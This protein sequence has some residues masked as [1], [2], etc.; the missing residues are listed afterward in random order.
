MINNF[1]KNA[2]ENTCKDFDLLDKKSFSHQWGNSDWI[3]RKLNNKKQKGVLLGDGVG[4]GKTY[5]ALFGALLYYVQHVMYKQYKDTSIL[6]VCPNQAVISKWRRD[7]FYIDPNKPN[8]TDYVKNIKETKK[9]IKSKNKLNQLLDEGNIVYLSEIQR[10]GKKE[11]LIKGAKHRIIFAT[12]HDIHKYFRGRSN[13][14]KNKLEE[15]IQI[16]II[17]EAHKLKQPK[18]DEITN[19]K[20]FLP[21]SKKI[22]LTATPF[23]K[24]AGELRKLLR[25][26]DKEKDAE[27]FKKYRDKFD[28]SELD[29][30]KQ[31]KIEL[32][33]RFRQYIAVRNKPFYN[34]KVFVNNKEV[35]QNIDKP[36][37][38]A[39]FG[40]LRKTS[41]KNGQQAINSSFYLYYLKERAA[42]CNVDEML[43]YQKLSL[44]LSM[45][46]SIAN[47]LAKHPKVELLLEILNNRFLVDPNNF[48]CKPVVFAGMN[49][50]TKK[51]KGL[52]KYLKEIIIDHYESQL[53][54]H[55]HEL[56]NSELPN[57]HPMLKRIF[58]DYPVNKKAKID[59]H[60]FAKEL[61]EKLKAS[62]LYQF[63]IKNG[64]KIK[65]YYEAEFKNIAEQYCDCC[66]TIS[67][68]NWSSKVKIEDFESHD[69]F[70]GFMKR[71]KKHLQVTLESMSPGE[72]LV[73]TYSSNESASQQKK[74]LAAFQSPLEPFVLIVSNA[75]SEGLDMQNYSRG[76]IH[77][78]MTWSPGLM[79]QRNGRINRIGKK[80]PKNQA[81]ENHYLIIPNTYDERIF[82]ALHKRMKALN[83]LIPVDV[84]SEKLFIDIDSKDAKNLKF[85]LKP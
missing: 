46:N 55:C 43:I 58:Q 6:I 49:V 70:I 42:F 68:K 14:I 47:N 23:Q 83:L 69:D 63:Y 30:L 61:I 85:N 37:I 45:P 26:I 65:D 44:L 20:D 9:Q 22:L 27:D 39:L 57:F 1:W 52:H 17:D 25:F 59:L 64:N 8:L 29:N 35:P 32:E 82:S 84:E 72:N 21:D 13:D 81:I 75:G 73:E 2:I 66:L 48:C 7:I 12:T 3:C 18:F 79:V 51:E 10:K 56:D 15:I 62:M 71:R 24:E 77:Y 78:D 19:K 60:S 4:T 5:S 16:A 34:I 80:C 33:K 67:K 28:C 74:S 40:N 53:N 38:E 41:D 76:C 11:N 54:E 36:G 31:D 50:G